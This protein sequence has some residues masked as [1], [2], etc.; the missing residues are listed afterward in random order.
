MH[1]EYQCL[2]KYISSLQ[3]VLQIF[4]D[5]SG[6]FRLGNKENAPKVFKKKSSMYLFVVDYSK[7]DDRRS[8]ESDA[9]IK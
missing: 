6:I 5:R 9:G 4:A 1:G 7:I 8:D 2:K 3:E